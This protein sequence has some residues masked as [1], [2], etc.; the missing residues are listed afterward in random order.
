MKM[1]ET[2]DQHAAPAI[3]RA[4]PLTHYRWGEGCDG[5]RLVETPGLRVR[6]ECIPPGA[7]ERPHLHRAGQ[8]AFYILSGALTVHLSDR[9]CRLVQ[10]DLLHVPAGVA[11]E[12]S[13]EEGDPVRFLVITA[14]A[15]DGDREDIGALSGE[16]AR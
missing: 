6:E 13:N 7:G 3:A 2:P 14:P 4:E 16:P 9:L 15:V 8:Q 11:H 12:V 5:R 10:G 1:T